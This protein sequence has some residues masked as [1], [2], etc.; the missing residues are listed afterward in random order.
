[1]AKYYS[2]RDSNNKVTHEIKIDKLKEGDT[3]FTDRGKC[4]KGDC[5][6]K[7]FMQITLKIAEI[8]VYTCK[9]HGEEMISDLKNN[10]PDATYEVHYY[11]P[12][13]LPQDIEDLRIKAGIEEIKMYTTD[14]EKID[15]LKLWLLDE[16][17]RKKE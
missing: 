10:Y 7:A 9:K 6:S 11:D 13:P 4:N 3:D 1:M 14:K 15:G 2:Y 16:I 12:Q 17:R 8:R 5:T